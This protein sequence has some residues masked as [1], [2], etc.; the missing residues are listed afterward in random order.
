MASP[1]SKCC[2]TQIALFSQS[3]KS[4]GTHQNIEI[5]SNVDGVKFQTSSEY[6]LKS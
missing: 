2:R 1:S 3:G 5:R 6:L 4:D